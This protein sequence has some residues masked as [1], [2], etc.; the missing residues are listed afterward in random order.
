MPL[1]AAAPASPHSGP[2][3]V[4]PQPHQ[5]SAIMWSYAKI[6]QPAAAAFTAFGARIPKCVGD[7]KP[8]ELSNI[9]WAYAKLQHAA[10][11]AAVFKA[12]EDETL[13]RIHEFGEQEL[14]N[15]AWAFGSRFML[16]NLPP[17]PT[18]SLPHSLPTR[19]AMALPDAFI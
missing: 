5:I 9:V 15:I 16:A 17:H 1:D 7:F 8:Q 14:S 19:S 13:K 6:E 18:F 10:K 3:L 12:V 4:R 11:A 2:P